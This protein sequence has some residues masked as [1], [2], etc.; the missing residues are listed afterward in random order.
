M[1]WK[2]AKAYTKKQSSNQGLFDTVDN[3]EK[4]YARVQTLS[5][6][7]LPLMKGIKF[8]GC[9]TRLGLLGVTDVHRSNQ[10]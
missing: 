8:L 3:S 1:L 5:A 4:Q 7:Q 9:T 2:T 10:W 6:L